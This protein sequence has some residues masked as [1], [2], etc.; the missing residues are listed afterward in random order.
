M[1][2]SLVG[3]VWSGQDRIESE[4]QCLESEFH[5]SGAAVKQQAAWSQTIDSIH[6]PEDTPIKR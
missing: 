5:A 2:W 6:P 3:L 4:V 1:Q